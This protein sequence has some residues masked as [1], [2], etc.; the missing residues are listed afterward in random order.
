MLKHSTA[1]H[2]IERFN[3][4]DILS[5]VKACKQL[6][7][8]AKKLGE[9]A[10]PEW[11]KL[12][13]IHRLQDYL[14]YEKEEVFLEDIREWVT[15][16]PVHT[17]N[18]DEELWYARFELS[19][20][21]VLERSGVSPG[22]QMDVDTFIKNGDVWCTSGSGF[23]PEVDKLEVYD[24]RLNE[25]YSV[26]KNKWS[27]RWQMSNYEAKKLLFKWRRQICK[28]IQKSEPGKVRA[29]ISSDLGL[30]LKMTYVSLYLDAIFK[31][32]TDSTLWMNKDER[33]K[34]WQ[35]MA[36]DGSWRMPIDQAEFDKNTSLRQVLITI[37]GIKKLL[38]KFKV[39]SVVLE[40]VDAIEFA[41]SGGF[42]IIGGQK[43][44][45]TNGILS[46]WRWTAMLDTLVNLAEL[47]M[48]QDW[49]RENSNIDPQL[50]SFN[51]QGDD[52]WLKGKTRKGMI[53]LW[54]AYDSFGLKVNP[55]KF[56][57]STTR[58]EY[59]RRVIDNENVIT[60]YPAR[61]LTSIF[62]NNPINDKPTVG[63][64]RIRSIFSKW[65][66]FA[67]R[68]GMLFNE[69]SYLFQRFIKDAKG[70]VEGVNK[71]IILEFLKISPLAGGIGYFD[72]LLHG[73]VPGDTLLETDPLMIRG[74][75]FAEWQSFASE[76]GVDEHVSSSFAVSTL[77]LTP[78]Y[79]LPKWVKY[80]Y[81]YD[82]VATDRPVGLSTTQDGTVAVGV[83]ALT[84]ARIFH[85]RWFSS[86]ND[87][88]H[89][90]T[91]TPFEFEYNYVPVYDKLQ[92]AHLAKSRTIRLKSVPGI[93]NT[94]ANLSSQPT[95]VWSNYP[96]ELL[97]HKPESWVKKFSSN[98]LKTYLSPR[99]GWGM[100]T[101]GYLGGTLLPSAI[102]VFLNTA[103]PSL[104]LWN[105]L[106][107]K[108]NDLLP[109]LLS[110]VTVRVS[111]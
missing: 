78:R 70:A 1:S 106:M 64:S 37:R 52:D 110:R 83:K 6:S 31:Q 109:Q 8:Y 100:D 76:Y 66:L 4:M 17:W 96:T 26:K 72:T 35:S 11:R 20:D 62:F 82:K 7:E 48:A 107:V 25:T 75:G 42:V 87:L 69:S 84:N 63:S 13:D 10:D 22:V 88:H 101:I 30:Y 39:P 46:G 59:L 102:N 61:S 105:T 47:D 33:F 50:L 74:A 108:I 9:L 32:R 44:P 91:H 79:S 27:T 95:L 5:D 104:M 67:M 90:Q 36:L 54:L 99:T 57:L 80:I 73:T 92:A 97:R 2:L 34:L 29:V 40:L 24:K 49:V 55:G 41:L 43:V 12:V 28:A 89:L 16:K 68:A 71:A 60:G 93:S 51:A 98:R 77:D 19:M 86:V 53:A 15:R 3:L 65:R 14:P 56:F 94:L 85:W 111:E 38:M 81:S 58:D 21:K 45:I 18:G 103:R 23:E